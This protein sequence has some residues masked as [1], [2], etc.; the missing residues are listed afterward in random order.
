MIFMAEKLAIFGGSKAVTIED[1]EAFG[2]WPIISEE[3]IKLVTDCLRK[4]WISGTPPIVTMF[5][6]AFAKYHN[7][8]YALAVN[9][10]TA[11]I[12]AA[13]FAVGVGPGDEVITPSY[14]WHCGVTPILACHGIPV[15]CEVDPKTLCADPEDVERKITSK[16]KAIL[17]THLWGVPAEMDRI[18]E[19]AEDHGLPV[20]EDASH[21]HGSIYKGRKVGSIGD[22]G[23]FSLQASKAMVAGEGGILITNNEEYLKWATALGNFERLWLWP[24][25][26]VY[27]FRNAHFGLKFRIHPLAAAIAY[28]QLKHLDEW[29]KIRRENHMYM[30]E[31]LKD[32]E[33]IEPPYIPSYVK[34]G[35]WYGFRIKYYPEK[36]LGV[37]KEKFIA[38]IRAE[39]VR[40]SL[41]RYPLLHLEPIFTEKNLQIRGGPLRCPYEQR[42]FYKKGDLPITEEVY[43]RLIALPKFQTK[44][45]KE[46]IDQYIE[47]FRKVVENIE[48]LKKKKI[49]RVEVPFEAGI[50]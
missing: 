36:L 7:V 26:P 12:Q 23:C 4:G 49:E 47:A 27:K 1:K 17:V 20:I 29:N 40:A 8:K 35:G 18:M 37:S 16:T 42:R 44:P 48:E 13:L 21:A 10:G 22:I 6:E 5:E 32:I 38:A 19:I 43:A 31:G 2:P 14:T 24:D 33:G 28:V 50:R 9:N 25:H 41:E 15:F 39:G 34:M 45:C 3:E 11:S 30:I 46:L